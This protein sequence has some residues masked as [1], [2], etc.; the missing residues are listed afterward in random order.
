MLTI[1][2]YDMEIVH[3]RDNSER[4]SV[5]KNA[6][7]SADIIDVIDLAKRPRLNRERVI[8]HLVKQIRVPSGYLCRSLS[9]FSLL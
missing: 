6:M 5:I 3:T 9:T 1:F 2:T 7:H 4:S 8:V